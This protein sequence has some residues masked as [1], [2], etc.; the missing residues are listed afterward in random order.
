[1]SIARGHLS[2]FLSSSGHESLQR[3]ACE[4]IAEKIYLKNLGEFKI[5]CDGEES[6]ADDGVNM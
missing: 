2:R 3:E 6:P 1:M 5:S 4:C